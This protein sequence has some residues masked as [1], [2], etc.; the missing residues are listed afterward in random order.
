MRCGTYGSRRCSPLIRAGL[1][2]EEEGDTM[3]DPASKGKRSAA[4][5]GGAPLGPTEWPNGMSNGMPP[6]AREPA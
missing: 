2:R 3:S 1:A 6:G 5:K 4:V